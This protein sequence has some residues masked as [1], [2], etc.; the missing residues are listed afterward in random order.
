MQ[1]KKA[2]N[3]LDFATT[4]GHIKSYCQALYETLKVYCPWLELKL[5]ER[6]LYYELWNLIDKAAL[7]IHDPAY[8]FAPELTFEDVSDHGS[9]A[10]ELEH[11]DS[12]GGS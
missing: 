8:K 6:A 4:T 10:E 9:S 7:K 11:S 3:N 5:I 12:S 1:L 2:L